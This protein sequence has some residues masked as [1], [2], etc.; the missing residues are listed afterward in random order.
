MDHIFE[1]HYRCPHCYQT[2]DSYSDAEVHCIEEPLEYYICTT[3]GFET[4]DNTDVIHCEKDH[5]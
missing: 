5:E 3:C 4:Y 1:T 2:C